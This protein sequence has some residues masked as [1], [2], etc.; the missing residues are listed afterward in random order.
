MTFSHWLTVATFCFLG[1]VSPGPSLAVIL[2]HTITGSRHNGITAAIA[3]GA[4]VG[5]FAFGV[6]MGLG[7]LIAQYPNTYQVMT[8]AGAAYLAWLAVQMLRSNGQAK[9][10]HDNQPPP[11]RGMAMRDGF[12]IVFLNPKLIIMLAALFS[13]F[14]QP[15][16]SYKIGLLLASTA[17]IIDTSWYVLVAYSLSNSKILPWLKNR[18]QWINRI[19]ATILFLLVIRVITL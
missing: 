1:A 4:G 3:H 19:T 5:I 17:W 12:L 15:G 6:A 18:T 7:H 8:Y 2:R 14:I 10:S 9:K 16:Q 11:S 13:Q